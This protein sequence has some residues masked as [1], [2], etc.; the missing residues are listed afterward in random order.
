MYNYLSVDHLC[1]LQHHHMSFFHIL[2][3]SIQI[4]MHF[5]NYTYTQKK[6]GEIEYT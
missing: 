2:S 5:V 1:R 3:S 4:H 6:N